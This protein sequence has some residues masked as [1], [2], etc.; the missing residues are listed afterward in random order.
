MV[1]GDLAVTHSLELRAE[2]ALCRPEIDV[3]VINQPNRLVI[4][5]DSKFLVRDPK[6]MRLLILINRLDRDSIFL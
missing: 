1:T 3:I 4:K 2:N 6:V 5:I